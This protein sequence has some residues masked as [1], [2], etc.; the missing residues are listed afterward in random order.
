MDHN[1]L[2]GRIA[3]M[4]M[5]QL[6]GMDS[7]RG[8]YFKIIEVEGLGQLKTICTNPGMTKMVRTFP[9]D[10]VRR[11]LRPETIQRQ[12]DPLKGESLDYAASCYLT[13]RQGGETDDMLKARLTAIALGPKGMN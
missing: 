9:A 4:A 8:M 12:L 13:E 1:D 3:G 7:A 11:Q 5:A 10:L 6:T 2:I